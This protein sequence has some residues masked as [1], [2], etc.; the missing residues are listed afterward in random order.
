MKL[1]LS[2]ANGSWSIK[3]ILGCSLTMRMLNDRRT[4]V[5]SLA[6]VVPVGWSV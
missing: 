2:L 5:A 1:A 6:V 3:T 4:D